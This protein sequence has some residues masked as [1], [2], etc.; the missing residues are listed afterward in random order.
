MGNINPAAVIAVAVKVFLISL[1]P[2]IGGDINTVPTAQAANLG[3]V[4]KNGIL[5][6][7]DGVPLDA[8]V[9]DFEAWIKMGAPDPREG[10]SLVRIVHR[11]E[12][13]GGLERAPERLPQYP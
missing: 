4:G 10:K 11:A 3:C 6:T 2:A 7:G 5:I 8:V 12:S 1:S 9:A 13:R